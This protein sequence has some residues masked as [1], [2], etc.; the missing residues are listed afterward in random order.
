MQRGIITFTKE[1]IDFLQSVLD[2]DL[3]QNTVLGQKLLAGSNQNGAKSD[4]DLSE[5]DSDTGD[6]IKVFLS[7]EEAETLMDSLPIPSEAGQVTVD[8]VV[9]LR[10][11]LQQFLLELGM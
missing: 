9:S 1:E 7:R 8:K 5:Q 10:E 3:L 6:M 11:K 4:A 2:E